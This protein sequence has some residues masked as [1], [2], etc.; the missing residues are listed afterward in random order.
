MIPMFLMSN[1]FVFGCAAREEF[2]GKKEMEKYSQPIPIVLD[3]K[4][5]CPVDAS[6]I[7]NAARKA[8]KTPI[9]FTTVDRYD[10]KYKVHWVSNRMTAG[11]WN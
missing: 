6:L 3:S 8:G 1:V 4:L 7:T 5:R 10:E 11:K 2:V 9:I